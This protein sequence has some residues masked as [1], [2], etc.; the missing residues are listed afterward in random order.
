MATHDYN[1]SVTSKYINM[2][3]Y[4]IFIYSP[5]DLCMKLAILEQNYSKLYP[6]V[7]YS[8][9]SQDVTK[10]VLADGETLFWAMP[11]FLVLHVLRFLYL[12]SG[13]S[14]RHWARRK[15]FKKIFNINNFNGF[16][17]ANPP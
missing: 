3:I 1:E 12:S 6:I 9:V 14:W 7:G 10:K 15:T 5:A 11:F 8:L 13:K 4:E 2:I 16:G 17:V